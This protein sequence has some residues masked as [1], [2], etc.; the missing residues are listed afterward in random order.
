MKKAALIILS[1]VL[2][3]CLTACDNNASSKPVNDA[4][5]EL[6]AEWTDIYNSQLNGLECDGY[7]EIKNTRVVK[8]DKT[9]IEIF[10][11]IDYIIEFVLYTDYFASA[12]YYSSDGGYDSVIVYKDGS[13]EISR[14]NLLR[15]YRS[16]YFNSDFSDIIKEVY[17][18]GDKYN[19][20]EHLKI[21]R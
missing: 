1:F 2:V 7:F 14:S 9:D 3:L 6:K 20:V 5:R 4:I 11:D 8:I 12:P 13:M 16:R 21:K 15:T 18:Y 10:S 19:C 17:D